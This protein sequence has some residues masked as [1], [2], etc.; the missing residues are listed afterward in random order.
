MTPSKIH[1]IYFVTYVWI[2]WRDDD[3]KSVCVEKKANYLQFYIGEEN[4]KRFEIETF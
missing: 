2:S 1:T 4:E 3:Q